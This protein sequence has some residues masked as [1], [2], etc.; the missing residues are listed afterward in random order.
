M[1]N[2]YYLVIETI[3]YSNHIVKD[4]RV[5]NKHPIFI[6]SS[7]QCTFCTMRRME[8]IYAMSQMII[9]KGIYWMW[10]L[11]WSTYLMIYLPML[12][13]VNEGSTL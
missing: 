6:S 9:L 13:A 3:C 7:E 11:W 10:L 12:D 2:K 5:F 4:S 8:A 1:L